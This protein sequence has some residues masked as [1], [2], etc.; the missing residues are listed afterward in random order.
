MDSSLLHD[1][2]KKALKNIY[3]T[4]MEAETIGEPEEFVAAVVWG[5]ARM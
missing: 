2:V 3:L 1:P 5:F 4:Q